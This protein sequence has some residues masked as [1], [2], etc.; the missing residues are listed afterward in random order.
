MSLP[1]R[2]L[3]T[4]AALALAPAAAAQQLTTYI[5]DFESTSPTDP[6]AIAADNWI[7]YGYVL[8]NMGQFA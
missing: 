1:L 3:A 8:D 2:A 4:T 7:V 5:Q 6:G